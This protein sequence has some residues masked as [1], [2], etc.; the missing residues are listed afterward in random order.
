MNATAAAWTNVW[1]EVT[2]ASESQRRRRL[3]PSHAKVRSTRHS[4][5]SG[6]NQHVPGGRFW[7]LV[8]PEPD[9]VA[10]ELAGLPGVLVGQLCGFPLMLVLL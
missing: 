8:G 1:D 2:V 5:W 7:P 10:A 4:G 3:R 9:L 6:T